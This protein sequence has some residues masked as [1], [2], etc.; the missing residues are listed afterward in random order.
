[1]NPMR[2]H[3][4]PLNVGRAGL[5]AAALGLLLAS[6][7][8]HAQ[9]VLFSFVTPQRT[10]LPGSPVTFSGTITNNS[11]VTE[12]LNGF[13][14]GALGPDFGG[15]G[16]TA[17]TTPFFNLTPLRLTPGQSTGVISLFTVT[18]LPTVTAG[19][20]TNF[21]NIE[22]GLDTATSDQMGGAQFI[23]DAAP[24]PEASTAASLGLLLL[25]VSVMVFKA[26][27]RSCRA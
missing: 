20:Y 15:A 26:R 10:V 9:S 8:A 27:R 23:V 3:L 18:A 17:D 1:M 12:F 22:G 16:L 19:S 5:L 24:L 21:F 25:G 2:T 13:D 7:V 4:S 6:Q 11:T 14:F